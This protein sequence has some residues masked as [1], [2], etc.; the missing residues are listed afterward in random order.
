MPVPQTVSVIGLDDVG[1]FIART[2]IERGFEVYGLD[3]L[4]NQLLVH[5]DGL[6]L[7]RNLEQAIEDSEAL[8]VCFPDQ[9]LMNARL[10]N[11]E[12]TLA[13]QGKALINFNIQPSCTTASVSSLS[14]WAK[15]NKTDYLEA[16]LSDTAEA[17]QNGVKLLCSGSLR[18]FQRL[19]PL[20]QALSNSVIYQ[21]NDCSASPINGTACRAHP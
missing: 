1:I 13:L 21:G 19:K 11:P 18:A 7:V 10:C 2:L 5:V 4:R 6:K 12:T 15:S 16:R 14:K 3:P 8:I 20:C 17:Y 9:L